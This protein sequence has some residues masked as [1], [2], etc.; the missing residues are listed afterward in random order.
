MTKRIVSVSDF[1]LRA[2]KG[3]R[4]PISTDWPECGYYRTRLVRG[5]PWRPVRIWR[6]EER[7]DDGELLHEPA[8]LC[9]RDGEAVAASACWP[10]A[11]MHPITTD[12]YL[13]LRGEEAAPARV[14]VNLKSMAPIF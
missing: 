11:A 1:W 8:T 14:A 3:E 7:G 4:L 9:L 5:G 12:E 10:W 2:L 6:E 13:R